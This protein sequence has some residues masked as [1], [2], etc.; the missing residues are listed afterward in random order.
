MSKL[1][2]SGQYIGLFDDNVHCDFGIIGVLPARVLADL[3]YH[4]EYGYMANVNAVVIKLQQFNVDVMYKIG[5]ETML[6]IESTIIQEFKKTREI[7][8]EYGV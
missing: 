6:D 3:F 4:R 2:C 1:K 7:E 8:D 5:K